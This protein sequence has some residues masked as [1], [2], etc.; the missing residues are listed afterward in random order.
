M[1]KSHSY[2]QRDELFREMTVANIR[3]DVAADNVEVIFLESARF[4]KVSKHNPK[5]QE[6]MRS[7]RDAIARG[8]ILRVR[9]ASPDSDIIEEVWRLSSSVESD[10]R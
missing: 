7:L 9:F 10:G 2:G 1:S 8:R 5:Y 3:D 4:Y 6:M